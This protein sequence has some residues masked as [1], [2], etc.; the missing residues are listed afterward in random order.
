MSVDSTFNA[1][2]GN[3]THRGG[4]QIGVKHYNERLILSLIQEAG[5]LSKAEIARITHLSSQTV[6]II[7]NRLLK[8]GYLRKKD[9]IRGRIGQPSTPIEIAPDGAISIGVKIGRRSLD[10]L[11]LSFD[12]R[13]IAKK[14]F[15]YDALDADVVSGLMGTAFDSL[16][17]DLSRVQKSRLVGVGIAAP[18][19]I[20]SGIAVIGDPGGASPRWREADMV[21]RVEVTS[22]LSAVVLN[23]ADAACLAEIDFRRENRNRSI[24]YFYISTL[25]GGSVV[26]EGNLITGHTGNAGAVGAIPLKLGSHDRSPAP[27]RL[28][29]AASLNRL[30]VLAAQHKL[31]MKTFREDGGSVAKLDEP[32]LACFDEWCDLAADALAF[33]AISGTSFIEADSVVVDG[34]LLRPLLDRLIVSVRERVAGYDLEGI[35]IP[36]FRVGSIGFNARAIGAAL[37]P[38]NEQFAPDNKVVLKS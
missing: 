24:V 32:A 11:A 31:P 8:E 12:R 4:N 28:S 7:V 23:D 9:V 36:E 20:E 3:A 27:A 17:D 21:A 6:T 38:L 35:I 33:A 5:A 19:A 1:F 2:V 18:T 25:I 37:V 29:Q 14:S 26:L 22:G 10:L 15:A 13:V 34:V 16:K 30:E